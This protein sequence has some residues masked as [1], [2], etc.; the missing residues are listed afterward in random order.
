M[1]TVKKYS[2]KGDT[3]DRTEC[4]FD[5]TDFIHIFTDKMMWKE[6]GRE[7]SRTLTPVYGEMFGDMP[8]IDRFHR[9]IEHKKFAI[10]ELKKWY[11]RHGTMYKITIIINGFENKYPSH[12]REGA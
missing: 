7:I 9:A 5:P 12:A 1:T 4:S 8:L 10:K 11:Y 3:S 6:L 2:G